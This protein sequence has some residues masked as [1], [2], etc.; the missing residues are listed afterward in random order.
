MSSIFYSKKSKLR[1]LLPTDLENLIL[2]Y[3]FTKLTRAA[4]YYRLSVILQ[5]GEQN[6]DVDIEKLAENLL[7]GQAKYHCHLHAT[8]KVRILDDGITQHHFFMQL[9]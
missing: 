2:S 4:G 7:L 1:L 9:T 6:S 3:E 5:T 8:R